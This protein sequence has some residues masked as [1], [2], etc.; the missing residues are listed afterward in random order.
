M[1]KGKSDFTVPSRDA[2]ISNK[3]KHR[4]KGSNVCYHT[5]KHQHFAGMAFTNSIVAA[6]E[7]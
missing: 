7:A 3:L 4:M 2:N 1:I 6:H 5:K